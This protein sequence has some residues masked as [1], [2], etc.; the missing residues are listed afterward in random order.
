MHIPQHHIKSTYTGL[1]EFSASEHE[2]VG[3]RD[4]NSF[5]PSLK[6]PLIAKIC[7]SFLINKTHVARTPTNQPLCYV[8]HPCLCP[9]Q[10]YPPLI[11]IGYALQR[12]PGTPFRTLH[13][14]IFLRHDLHFPKI[15]SKRNNI[16]FPPPI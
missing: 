5:S 1:L 10:P 14:I 9:E 7:N 13:N 16:Y 4:K 3:K 6:L 11:F 15:N 2:N 8:T 12:R